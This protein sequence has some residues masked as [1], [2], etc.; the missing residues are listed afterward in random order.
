M[1]RVSP[2][3]FFRRQTYPQQQA[4]NRPTTQ[5]GKSFET[6]KID[7]GSRCCDILEAIR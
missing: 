2:S 4:F 5:L 6:R 1:L 3:S 7:G